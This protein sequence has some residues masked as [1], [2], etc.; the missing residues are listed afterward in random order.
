MLPAGWGGVTHVRPRYYERGAGFP[1]LANDLAEQVI[2]SEIRGLI[3][4]QLDNID[5]AKKTGAAPDMGPWQTIIDREYA[6]GDEKFSA[7]AARADFY[8]QRNRYDVDHVNPLAG[9]WNKTGYNSDQGVRVGATQG[10]TGGLA[11]LEKSINRSKGSGGVTYQL[12]VGSGFTSPGGDQ[13]H[14]DA[15]EPFKDFA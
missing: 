15:G 9:H 12:W 2:N 3:K 14:A 7:K 5:D 10:K 6:K 11:L 1:G 13:F 8:F 4:K